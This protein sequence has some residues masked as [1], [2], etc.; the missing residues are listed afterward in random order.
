ML[1]NNAEVLLKVYFDDLI[2]LPGE[3]IINKPSK[4]TLEGLFFLVC[5]V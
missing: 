4:D 1:K 3:Y 2:D 5:I